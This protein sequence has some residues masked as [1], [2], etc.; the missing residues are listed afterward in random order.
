MTEPWQAEREWSCDEVGAVVRAQC[1][2]LPCRIVEPF[3]CGW[4]NTAFLIDRE[5]V[6]R[7]VRRKFAVPLLERE[8]S[9]L[10]SLSV[11]LPIPIPD[12]QW[13]GR[14][15]DWPFAGYRRLIGHCASDLFLDKATRHTLAGPLGEFLRTLHAH[16][17]N[18]LRVEPD[19]LGRLDLAKWRPRA[20]QML[21]VCDPDIDVAGL[22][23]VLDAVDATTARAVLSHGDLYARHVLLNDGQ[24]SGIIDWGDVC[25]AEPAVDLAIAFTFLPASARNDFF[26]AYGDIDAATASRARFRAIAHTLNVRRY[27]KSIRDE[28]LLAEA[29][30]AL[31]FIV[32]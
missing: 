28:A 4:D 2:A 10:P 1:P 11:S 15:D 22:R 27:A 17:T 7:F 19:A 24:L 9:V 14:V 32:E 21:D 25:L 26:A 5:W 31:Q 23:S 20:I 13:F 29:T 12:P 18:E 30:L 8:I 6:F 16:S 3:G